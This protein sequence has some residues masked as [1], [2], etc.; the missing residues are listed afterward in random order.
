MWKKGLAAGEEY[1]DVVRLCRDATRMA[2][3]S[4][5]YNVIST[6]KYLKVFQPFKM[7]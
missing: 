4:W 5:N 7:K 3:S 6:G 2:K 1:K